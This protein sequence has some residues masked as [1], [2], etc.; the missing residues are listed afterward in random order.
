MAHLTRNIYRRKSERNFK[1]LW[2]TIALFLLSGS[3]LGAGYLILWS[4]LF[5][6]EAVNIFGNQTASAE[7]IKEVLTGNFGASFMRRLL[8]PR[9]LFFWPKGKFA[10]NSRR[11][12]ALVYAEVEKDWQK[13]IV[14][15]KAEERKP[16]GILCQNSDHQ[17]SN[18]CY[19]FDEEGV[20]FDR[21]PSARGFLI[22]K[23]LDENQRNLS[24]NDQIF[25]KPEFTENLINLMKQMQKITL[26]KPRSFIIKDLSLR[27][28]HVET[29]GPE[30]YFS[31]RSVPKNIEKILAGVNQ[32]K[33]LLNL[34]Y[35]DLRVENR[36]YHK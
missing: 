34:S 21:S 32:Q 3:A 4:D 33:K 8:G 27:E 2:G 35:L 7:E 23:V 18:G 15:I 24:L 10:I 16:F 30:L 31:L 28:I 26:L 25:G 22:P 13:K 11:L 20:L 19:W 36:I 5:K 29:N 14:D 1:F 12:P 9:S 17:N 6:A